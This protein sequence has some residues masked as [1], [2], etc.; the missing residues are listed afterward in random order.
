MAEIIN[1][2]DPLAY[3]E[4]NSEFIADCCRF[5]EKILTEAQ[6][7]RKWRFDE[8]VFEKTRRQ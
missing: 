1:L 4:D 3:L 5:A 7:K 2:H 8:A 6:V